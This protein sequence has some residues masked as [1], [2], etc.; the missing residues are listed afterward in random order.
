MSWWATAQG[1]QGVE[2]ETVTAK[3]LVAGRNVSKE[4]ATGT[5]ADGATW[6]SMGEEALPKG[7]T[8]VY[9]RH[10]QLVK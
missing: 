1:G 7:L 9:L 2:T 3:I 5:L 4:P 10:N 8:E 6:P